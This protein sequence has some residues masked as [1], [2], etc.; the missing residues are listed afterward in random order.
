MNKEEFEFTDFFTVT[1]QRPTPDIE[2]TMEKTSL[3]EKWSEKLGIEYNYND[4]TYVENE[5][6][7]DFKCCTKLAV[8]K[9][10]I[11]DCFLKWGSLGHIG[12]LPLDN[13]RAMYGSSSSSLTNDFACSRNELNSDLFSKQMILFSSFGLEK[14]FDYYSS[15]KNISHK[16]YSLSRICFISSVESTS[17]FTDEFNNSRILAAEGL[18]YLEVIDLNNLNSA[19]FSDMAFLAIS[20]QFNSGNESISFFSSKGTAN[21]NVGILSP[22]PALNTSNYVYYVQVYKHFDL[23][24]NKEEDRVDYGTRYDLGY[25]VSSL[26]YELGYDVIDNVS[27][28]YDDCGL[29]YKLEYELGYEVGSLGY[30]VFDDVIDNVSIGHDS[31]DNDK[32]NGELTRDDG[33]LTQNNGLLMRNNEVLEKKVTIFT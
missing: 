30:D 17:D 15:I 8:S 7:A 26:G 24:N 5:Y 3:G 10:G 13:E 33:E 18:P 6:P 29:E 21:V 14:T 1:F 23:K 25:E 19:A 27:I 11:K 31:Y 20:D 22:P 16:E 32:A 9:T 28:D 12:I 2:K 4:Y